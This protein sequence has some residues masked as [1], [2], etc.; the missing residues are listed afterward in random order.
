MNLPMR[1]RILLAAS[2]L[3][4]SLPLAGAELVEKIV[5]RVNDRLI[6]N[7]EF[8][9]RFAVFIS[10]P[11]AG[12]NPLE[13][14]RKLLSE[15]I[16][17]KLLEERAKELS[18]AAT[19]EEVETA[20]ERVKRQYNLAT[21]AEFDNALKSS[22][23][24]RE[25]LKRQMKNTITL[26]KVIGRDINS[27]LDLSDDTLRLEYER[28]K[29]QLYKTPDQ[30]Q[31]AEI[32]IRFD[33]ND[34]AARARAASRIEEARAKITAGAAFAD[35]A[36]QYSEGNARER[37]GALGTVSKGELVTALDAAVFSDPPAEYPPA[38]LLSSSIHLFHVTDRK[39]AGYRPFAEVKDDLRARIGDDLYDKHYGEYIQKLRREAFIKI[40][41][42]ALAAAKEEKK[43]S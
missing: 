31:V 24:T 33:A 19:D 30:A 5:A 6:T 41:E 10:S 13:A 23:L 37:G 18:V 42:P 12:N 25:D 22:N 27:K 7:S 26:Q 21:D 8:E 9:A 14:K 1:N 16:D 39:S 11:Q 29:D 34:P 43:A 4:A 32:V 3:L 2:V 35:V 40:Y 36:K 15:L 17:E 28:R 20:V 38:V